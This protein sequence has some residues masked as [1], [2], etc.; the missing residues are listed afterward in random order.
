MQQEKACNTMLEHQGAVLDNVECMG[1][2]YFSVGFLF[3]PQSHMAFPNKS[4][5]NKASK[6][7]ASKINISCLKSYLINWTTSLNK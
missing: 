7:L 2:I 6:Y 1:V 3:A 4:N 5:L